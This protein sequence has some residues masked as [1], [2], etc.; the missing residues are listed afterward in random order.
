M[1]SKRGLQTLYFINISFSAFN[2]LLAIIGIAFTLTKLFKIVKKKR[3]VNAMGKKFGYETCKWKYIEKQLRVTLFLLILVVEWLF[4]TLYNIESVVRNAYR[5]SLMGREFTLTNDC[6]LSNETYLAYQYDKSVYQVACN[7][8]K[9]FQQALL[10]YG[11]WMSYLFLTHICKAM[12]KLVE[13]KKLI[14]YCLLGGIVAVIVLIISVIPVLSILNIPIITLVKEF[15]LILA[16]IRAMSYLSLFHQR[17]KD[18]ELSYTSS[19]PY[20]QYRRWLLRT[21]FV[22]IISLTVLLQLYILGDVCYISYI[23]GETVVR[24]PCWIKSTLND[25][26]TTTRIATKYFES[27]YIT[28]KFLAR[29]LKMISNIGIFITQVFIVICYIYGRNKPKRK[30][31]VDNDYTLSRSLLSEKD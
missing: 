10:V 19:S 21:Y 15:I 2:N 25:N 22:T 31:A 8:M 17:N 29:I 20:M 23:V 16:I 12:N 13:R 11:L 18:L 3:Y 7:I 24:N 9:S 14:T 1:D 4:I 28:S 5:G 30:L 27:S 6:V 26:F